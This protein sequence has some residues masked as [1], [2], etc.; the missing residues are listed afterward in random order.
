[1][2]HRG[3]DARPG[4][5]RWSRPKEYLCRPGQTARRRDAAVND[6]GGIEAPQLRQRRARIEQAGIEEV[7]AGAP[8]LQ[9]ELTEAQ[10]AAID[11][12]TDEIALIRCM[13]KAPEYRGFS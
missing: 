12:K 3:H 9:G 7:W 10:N 1:M 11:G 13:K 6:G 8:G 4:P 2:A 5:R